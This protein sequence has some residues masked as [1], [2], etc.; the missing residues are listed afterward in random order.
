VY[1]ILGLRARTPTF[2]RKISLPSSE[3][4]SN[5]SKNLQQVGWPLPLKKRATFFFETSVL[6]RL[7]DVIS[8]KIELFIATAVRVSNPEILRFFIHV[9]STSDV[10]FPSGVCRNV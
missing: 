3:L 2:R 8:Q 9:I 6:S 4:K 5:P 7:R 1:L 10:T